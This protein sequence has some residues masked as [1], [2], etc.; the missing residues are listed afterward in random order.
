[1][2]SLRVGTGLQTLEQE[3]GLL[4]H[5]AR[6]RQK[7]L[8]VVAVVAQHYREGAPWGQHLLTQQRA[9]RAPQVGEELPG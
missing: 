9:D 2:F 1:V 3:C 7:A 4:A 8:A 6:A 5:S